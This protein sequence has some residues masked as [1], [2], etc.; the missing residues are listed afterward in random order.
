M[1]NMPFLTLLEKY[2]LMALTTFLI[3]LQNVEKIPMLKHFLIIF[4]SGYFFSIVQA[5]LKFKFSTRA[6]D[7]MYILFRHF[8]KTNSEEEKCFTYT[9]VV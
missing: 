5:E 9:V 7:K 3:S 6:L 4:P 8:G 1:P 2:P